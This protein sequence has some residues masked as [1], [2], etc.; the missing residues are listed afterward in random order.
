MHPIA[1]RGC[2][3]TVR[4]AA[5]KIDSGRKIPCRT[6]KSNLRQRLASPRLYQLSCIPA[7]SHANE[8]VF[9][10][11]GWCRPSATKRFLRAS[12]AWNWHKIRWIVCFSVFMLYVAWKRPLPQ[13]F[14]RFVLFHPIKKCSF[15]LLCVLDLFSECWQSTWFQIFFFHSQ[16]F[17][18][19]E[20]VLV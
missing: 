20:N 6:G 5:L 4:E 17:E 7:S 13:I 14:S 19:V 3:D 10:V 9:F 12:K 11:V 16:I 2:V 15:N 1:R 18:H 8:I